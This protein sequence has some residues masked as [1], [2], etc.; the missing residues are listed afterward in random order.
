MQVTTRLLWNSCGSSS[1]GSDG[2][3]GVPFPWQPLRLGPQKV[4]FLRMQLRTGYGLTPF[5]ES[6]P[7]R[8]HIPCICAE[9]HYWRSSS[10]RL[11]HNT[12]LWTSFLLFWRKKKELV[13]RLLSW[14][15]V[16]SLE[17]AL[18]IVCHHILFCLRIRLSRFSLGN[19][20]LSKMTNNQEPRGLETPSNHTWCTY[21]VGL[22]HYGPRGDELDLAIGQSLHLCCVCPCLSVDFV[23]FRD[24]GTLGS[25]SLMRYD[26]A[27]FINK[28]TKCHFSCGSSC[29][30][31]W[32]RIWKL[33]DV[34]FRDSFHAYNLWVEMES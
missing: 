29:D 3:W 20:N 14:G 27:F 1:F 6:M 21:V 15:T 10:S 7:W 25:G 12:F 32:H 5:Y 8:L 17:K 23:L 31:D 11:L 16:Q 4:S 26:V 2:G 34:N 19:R 9:L 13:R 30:K 28:K 22:L 33:Q 18:T 24:G